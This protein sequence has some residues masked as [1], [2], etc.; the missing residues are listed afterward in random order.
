M[1]EQSD[2]DILRNA[3]DKISGI[4]VERIMV[5][6]NRFFNVYEPSV[7]VGMKMFEDGRRELYAYGTTSQIYFHVK[8][9]PDFSD[10]QISMITPSNNKTIE[11]LKEFFGQLPE[12]VTTYKPNNNRN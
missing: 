6:L 10:I 7:L 1:S 11:E 4:V 5:S 8:P 3:V 9:L 12:S 2:D